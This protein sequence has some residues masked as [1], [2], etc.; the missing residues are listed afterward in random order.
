MAVALTPLAPIS[1]P[2]WTAEY[3]GAENRNAVSNK[4]KRPNV[5]VGK[6]SMRDLLV[7]IK[8]ESKVLPPCQPFWSKS[9]LFSR[10]LPLLPNARAAF[11]ALSS[12]QQLDGNVSAGSG[13]GQGGSTADDKEPRAAGKPPSR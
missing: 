2:A 1:M 5:R 4:A 10:A 6:R 11:T 12:C 9:R 3:A 8:N 7:R 13:E